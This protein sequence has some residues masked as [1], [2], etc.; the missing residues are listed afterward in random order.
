MTR[1]VPVICRMLQ[2]P[3]SAPQEEKEIFWY[4][5]YDFI[6]SSETGMQGRLLHHN[7]E[8]ALAFPSHLYDFSDLQSKKKGPWPYIL[9]VVLRSQLCQYSEINDA[10]S[11][12]VLSRAAGL[13]KKPNIAVH[14]V[15][16]RRP[17]L[18]STSQEMIEMTWQSTTS[19]ERP[20]S[21]DNN[22]CNNNI[23]PEAVLI[24]YKY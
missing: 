4:H 16:D 3:Q 21:I 1:E 22:D 12:V 24:I 17:V 8:R 7:T 20:H 18:L 23:I 9:E 2:S 11:H 13:I 6:V 19:I 14:S 5:H 10:G 15:G